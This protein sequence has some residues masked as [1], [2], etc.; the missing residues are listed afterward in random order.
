M[1]H[2]LILLVLSLTSLNAATKQEIVAATL[3]A[4]A[5]GETSKGAMEA[6]N[7]VIVNR[8]A[9]RRISADKVCLQKDQFSCWNGKNVDS[10]VSKAKKHPKWKIALSIVNSPKT[11]FT[12][13]ADHYHT[14]S[15][16]PKWNRNMDIVKVIGAHIFYRG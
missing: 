16:N 3:I 1:K 2:I 9:S 15:V 7:E 5:G 13:G 14:K 6:V 4:E 10:V 12:K 8:S 11:N